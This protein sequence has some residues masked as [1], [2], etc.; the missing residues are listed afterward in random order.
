MTRVAED[1]L[2]EG[3]SSVKMTCSA[4]ANPP[5][6]VFWRKYGASEE[7]QFVETLEFSPVMRKDSGT[8]VCQAENSIGISAEETVEVD[9][10]CKKAAF[11][12]SIFGPSVQFMVES[13]SSDYQ[14]FCCNRT[15]YHHRYIV[16][17]I[18]QSLF[19]FFCLSFKK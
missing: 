5:A 8:Y 10:L 18:S 19:T 4:D 15:I 17:A 16:Q 11:P 3:R 9:V 12:G 2:E 13:K 6:R 7:R 14:N 1:I